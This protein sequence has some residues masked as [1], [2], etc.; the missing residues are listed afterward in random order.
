MH[1]LPINLSVIMLFV[2]V[3]FDV[4]ET[5]KAEIISAFLH[6]I[7]LVPYNTLAIDCAK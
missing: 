2:V 6:L 4:V 3:F 1:F 5:K 7:L